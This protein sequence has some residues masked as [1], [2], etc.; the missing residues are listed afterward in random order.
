MCDKCA[1]SHAFDHGACDDYELG[2]NGRCVYC[3]HD[4]GCH[5]GEGEFF[6]QPLSVGVRRGHEKCKPKRTKANGET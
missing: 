3:D 4:E 1:C 2:R 6:N 5:P